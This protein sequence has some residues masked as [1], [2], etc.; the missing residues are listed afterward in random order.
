MGGTLSSGLISTEVLI[1]WPL[2]S[3]LSSL[4]PSQVIQPIAGKCLPLLPETLWRRWIVE[5]F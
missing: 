1:L 4:S 5:V 3:N 2:V